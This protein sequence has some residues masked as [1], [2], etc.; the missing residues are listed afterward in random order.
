ML[1]GPLLCPIYDNKTM[2][3][4]KSKSNLLQLPLH[5]L[6]WNSIFQ[7]TR[8]GSVIKRKIKIKTALC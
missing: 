5:R 7:D 6:K 8:L 3:C 2:Y 1:T 4:I